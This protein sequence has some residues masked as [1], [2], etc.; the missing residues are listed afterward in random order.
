MTAA[1]QPHPGT[2]Q[3]TTGGSRHTPGMF[4]DGLING[5]AAED[6]EL[7]VRKRVWDQQLQRD[8]EQLR[9]GAKGGAS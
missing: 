8:T 9:T 6:W 7:E 1:K 2:R 4:Q 3:G 5:R